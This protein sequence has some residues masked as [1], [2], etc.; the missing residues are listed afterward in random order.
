MVYD[1]S[2]FNV[3]SRGMIADKLN[4]AKKAVLVGAISCLGHGVLV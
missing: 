2:L 1:V 4:R 3:Y